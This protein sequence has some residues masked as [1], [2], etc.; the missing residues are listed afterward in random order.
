MNCMSTGP[1]TTA[2]S[3]SSGFLPQGRNE[4]AAL[5]W[6]AFRGKLG[7]VM[8]P[9]HKALQFF[10]T[11]LNPEFALTARDGVGKILGL[12]GFKTVNGALVGGDLKQLAQAYGWLG[13]A[14]RGALLS[15]LERRIEPDI[16]LMDGIFV[17][18]DARG[19]GIGTALLSAIKAHAAQTGLNAV[20]LDVID[21]NQRAQALY[22]REGFIAAGIEELGLLRHLFGFRQSI[23]MECPVG[24]N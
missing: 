11:V 23:R 2:I 21:T 20:R 6:Q 24:G 16:L 4:V 5:Y 15:L 8:N 1:N 17:G 19:R 18:A 9:E 14:W 3:I 12:A 7:P 22:E 10:T 13:A